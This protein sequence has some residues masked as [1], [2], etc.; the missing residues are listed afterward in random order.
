VARWG[1]EGARW[2]RPEPVRVIRVERVASA[3]RAAGTG[4]VYREVGEQIGR[5]R[6]RVRRAYAGVVLRRYL[7]VA[8]ALAIIAEAAARIATSGPRPLWAL[9]GV[10]VALVG[11]LIALSTPIRRD[12]V[13]SLLDRGLGLADRTRTALEL[14]SR[15]GVSSPLASRVTAEAQEALGSSFGSA[16]VRPGPA[17]AEWGAAA[18]LAAVLVLLLVLPAG[19]PSRSGHA[20]GSTHEAGAPVA[21]GGKG[22]AAGLT[23]RN[24]PAPLPVGAGVSTVLQPPLSI[25]PSSSQATKGLGTS[26]YGHG[27][28]STGSY[29]TSKTGLSQATAGTRIIAAPGSGGGSPNAGASGGSARGSGSAGAKSS[30][31]SG[32]GG[33][34]SPGAAPGSAPNARA[35]GHGGGTPGHAGSAAEGGSESGRSSSQAAP[36]GGENAGTS[37][38]STQLQAGLAPQLGQGQTGLPLQA[39]YAPTAAREA[40]H[41]AISQTPNGGGGKARS[42]V[43]GGTAGGGGGPSDVTAIEPTPNAG[44]PAAQPLVSGYFGAANQLQPGSW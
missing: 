24:R 28:V 41:G 27:A 31:Q 20:R 15:P 36:P 34:S 17:G 7:A 6:G 39:G 21:A 13:A 18:V 22:T 4:L 35:G 9:A 33:L 26:P 32:S 23:H 11:S 38:G 25:A 10:A 5:W 40:G 8:F 37:R 14:E 12:R 29:V 2:L 30:G 3:A 1:R 43:G 44:A 42:E 16:R 19:G